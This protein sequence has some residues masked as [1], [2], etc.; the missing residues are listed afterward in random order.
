MAAALYFIVPMSR[1][2][3]G[4]TPGYALLGL[5]LV[6][7]EKLQPPSLFRPLVWY[8]VSFARLIGWLTYFYDSHHRMLHDLASGTLVIVDRGRRE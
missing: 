6:D 1:L 4:Q 3:G 2:G 5:R 8:I 7:R